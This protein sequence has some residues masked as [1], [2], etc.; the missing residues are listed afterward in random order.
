M[1]FNGLVGHYEID[2]LPSQVQVAI[3]HGFYVHEGLRG[4]G[5]AKQLHKDQIKNLIELGYDYAVC[6]VTGDNQAQS[7]AIAK[8]GWELMSE[9]YNTRKGE[10]TQVW[11]FNVGAYLA[12][13]DA[14]GSHDFGKQAISLMPALKNEG[15]HVEAT[16]T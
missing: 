15:Y 11:H 9:F 13:L 14:S 2:S 6:T 1:R 7:T 12:G 5:L 4:Q 8:A 10:K 16:P 3:C